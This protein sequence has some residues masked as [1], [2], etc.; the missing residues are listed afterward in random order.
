MLHGSVEGIFDLLVNNPEL[1][2]DTGVA[3]G[4]ELTWDE[5]FVVYDSIV[6]SLKENNIVPANGERHVYYKECSRQLRILVKMPSDESKITFV[7]SGDGDMVVDWGDNTNLETIPLKSVEQQYDHYFD[8]STD[9]RVVKIYG[10]FSVKRFDASNVN[11][12]ILPVTPIT[13]DEF[14]CN[15]NNMN[16]QGLFLFKGT[17]LV[18]LT[19]RT[20]KS[21]DSIRDMS[22]QK[23][24]LSGNDYM[25]GSCID[26]YLIYVAKNTNQRRN[27]YVTLDIE[28]SGVYQ[29]PKKDA[30]GNYVIRTG[31]EAIYVITHEVAWN[32]A[33]SWV[34]NIK[35]KIYKYENPNI[36]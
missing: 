2:F 8:N 21:L 22:L 3:E 33:G 13:V 11:G 14:V 17:Y 23:L 35:G 10:D 4:Q 19:K 12:S 16:L 26:N 6:D 15:E 27:C 29:E 31:M 9:Y 25:P 5:D 28:P 34:F 18:E 24:T 30:N 20:I 7:M 36:A 32:E 1:S